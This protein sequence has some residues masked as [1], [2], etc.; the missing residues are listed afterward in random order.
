MD[1]TCS[2]NKKID[3]KLLFDRYPDNSTK[4]NRAHRLRGD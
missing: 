3:V 1:D 4:C 2:R